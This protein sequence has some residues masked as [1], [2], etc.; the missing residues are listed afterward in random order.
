[1]KTRDECANQSTHEVKTEKYSKIKIVYV[2]KLKACPFQPANVMSLNVIRKVLDYKIKSNLVVN[3]DKD[4]LTN[5]KAKQALVGAQ[6]CDNFCTYQWS[7]S[8]LCVLKLQIR[9]EQQ[10]DLWVIADGKLTNFKRFD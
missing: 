2:V 4:L 9:T 8:F 5:D 6:L 7:H 1:M 10:V 3:E